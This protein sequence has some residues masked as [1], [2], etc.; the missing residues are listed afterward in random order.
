MPVPIKRKPAPKPVKS[1]R[2]V[3]CGGTGKS[4]RGGPCV[5]CQRR[6]EKEAQK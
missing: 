1:T 4:S 3:A 2:C 5:P 6:Q